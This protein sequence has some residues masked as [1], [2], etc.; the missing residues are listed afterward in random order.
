MYKTDRPTD[1]LIGRQLIITLLCIFVIHR[2]HSNTPSYKFLITVTT[3]TQR[4]KKKDLSV[5]LLI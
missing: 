5:D 2:I 3:N 4:L 1:R